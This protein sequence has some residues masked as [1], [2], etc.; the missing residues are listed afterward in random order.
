MTTLEKVKGDY[1]KNINYI[2]DEVSAFT[3][4][5]LDKR[6]R[7]NQDVFNRPVERVFDELEKTREV[8]KTLSTLFSDSDGIVPS[9]IGELELKSSLINLD[10][11]NYFFI[12]FEQ[13]VYK[14]GENVGSNID[15]KVFAERQLES[16]FELNQNAGESV[17][18]DK[19]PVVISATI[20]KYNQESDTFDTF[21]F[22]GTNQ[23]LLFE[24]IYSDA[25]ILGSM[26]RVK[27]DFNFHKIKFENWYYIGSPVPPITNIMFFIKNGELDW[28]DTLLDDP[29][30]TSTTN[31]II[32]SKEKFSTFF[33][34]EGDNALPLYIIQLDASKEGI[35]STQ[36]V[37]FFANEMSNKSVSG[38]K[39]QIND[40][41]KKVFSLL[42]STSR[43]I[44]EDITGHKLFEITGN[45]E[46]IFDAETTFQGSTTYVN[47]ANLSIQDNIIELNKPAAGSPLQP[48][49]SGIVVI[50]DA[51]EQANPNYVKN[52]RI[53]WDN[54]NNIWLIRYGDSDNVVEGEILTRQEVENGGMNR[55][56]FKDANGQIAYIRYANGEFIFEF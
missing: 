37:R 15:N 24:Q 9:N 23:I 40:D 31:H 45:G 34:L 46:I 52:P 7:P 22:A 21:S 48:D 28:T 36:D 30:P 44:V 25:G 27:V 29:L 49:D 51:A 54:E 19:G 13:G 18:L 33:S 50:R 1:V 32:Q 53:L 8:L 43:F 20:R 55:V 16:I 12:G 39:E 47:T 14:I 35:V 2:T 56:S 41:G 26:F 6:E 17:V 3:Y 38:I 11:T 10:G 5:L 4:E 42:N